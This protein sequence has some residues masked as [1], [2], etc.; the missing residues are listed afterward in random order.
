MHRVFDA[1]LR[2]TRTRVYRGT[3]IVFVALDVVLDRRH[4]RLR[5]GRGACCTGSGFAGVWILWQLVRRRVLGIG[6]EG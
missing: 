3:D 2:R 4:H 1:I 5:C 6:R